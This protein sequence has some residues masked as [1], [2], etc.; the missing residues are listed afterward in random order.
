MAKKT[1]KQRM[2]IGER[3]TYHRGGQA[4]ELA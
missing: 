2:K 3:W 1:E 4:G